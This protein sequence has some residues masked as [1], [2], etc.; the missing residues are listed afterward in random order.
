MD[1]CDRATHR[2]GVRV[3]WRWWEHTGIDLEGAK[4]RV[5]DTT[6]I[7]ESESEEESYMEANEDSGGEE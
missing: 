7:L 1:L 3:S 2:P 5:V 6:T 4:K